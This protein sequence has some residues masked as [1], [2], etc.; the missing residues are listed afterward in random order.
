MCYIVTLS[1]Q[2]FMM[3]IHSNFLSVMHGLRDREVSVPT[4]YI[5]IVISPPV[6]A[7]L[8]FS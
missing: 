2:D 7:S 5:V 4:G 8:D 3:V 1:D 6:G